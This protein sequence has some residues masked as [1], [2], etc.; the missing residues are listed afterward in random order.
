[1]LDTKIASFP[2]LEIEYVKSLVAPPITD[3][4]S[5][6]PLKEMTR[7]PVGPL[8]E[9]G[10]PPPHPT[11]VSAIASVKFWILISKLG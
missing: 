9:E 6:L 10:D 3:P 4:K 1:M 7:V 11:S 2:E 5:R 8:G